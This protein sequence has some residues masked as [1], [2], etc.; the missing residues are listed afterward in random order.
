MVL[1]KLNKN[2]LLYSLKAC[3][4]KTGIYASSHQYLSETLW[5]KWLSSSQRSWTNNQ[6]MIV[7]RQIQIIGLVKHLIKKP[8]ADYKS[9]IISFTLT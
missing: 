9:D 8:E 1:S 2:S 7:C 4:N 6:S 5:M 3:K